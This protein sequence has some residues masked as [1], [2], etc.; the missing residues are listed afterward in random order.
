MD[1]LKANLDALGVGEEGRIIRRDAWMAATRAPDGTKF[2]LVF[3][4]P[5]F[6]SADWPALCEQ[7]HSGGWLVEGA[8]VYLE[9][10]AG[11]GEPSLPHGWVLL[12]SAKAGNV[13]YHLASPPQPADREGEE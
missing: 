11:V 7:L 10:A 1:A 12:R 9:D 3:L 13:G 8:R 2:D 6:G 4:D 5:P